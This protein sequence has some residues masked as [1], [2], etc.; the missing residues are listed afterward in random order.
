MLSKQPV[1]QVLYYDSEIHRKPQRRVSSTLWRKA[2]TLMEVF[3][4]GQLRA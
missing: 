4:D 3:T 1:K 2:F